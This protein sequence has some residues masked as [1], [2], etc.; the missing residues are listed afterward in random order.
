MSVRIEKLQPMRIA[1]VHHHGPY[2][3]IGDVWY[4][5]HGSY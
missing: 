2:H 5:F 4:I 1:Y 3:E